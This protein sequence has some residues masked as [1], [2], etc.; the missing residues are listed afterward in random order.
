MNQ[1]DYII[2]FLMWKKIINIEWDMFMRNVRFKKK[3]KYVSSIVGDSIDIFCFWANLWSICDDGRSILGSHWELR[4][5]VISN[6]IQVPQLLI[7][8]RRRSPAVKSI[9]GRYYRETEAI[10]CHPCPRLLLTSIL[11]IIRC[12]NITYCSSFSENITAAGA[13]LLRTLRGME[14]R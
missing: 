9:G 12:N 14:A 7:E 1:I 11:P 2:I 6:C 8:T 10:T 4:R 13:E 3:N 5:L